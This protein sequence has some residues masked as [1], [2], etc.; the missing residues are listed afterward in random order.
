MRDG[1]AN[2]PVLSIRGSVLRGKA[3]RKLSC[4]KPRIAADGS[5]SRMRTRIRSETANDNANCQGYTP[6]WPNSTSV[7]GRM[8]K[9]PLSIAVARAIEVAIAM[10]VARTPRVRDTNRHLSVEASEIDN[11]LSKVEMSV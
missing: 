11:N 7:L 3:F 2:L 8:Q 9:K 6:A 1:L 4:V 10:A 5:I